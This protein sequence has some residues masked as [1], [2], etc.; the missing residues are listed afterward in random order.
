MKRIGEQLKEAGIL[1]W[2]DEWELQP[3]QPWQDELE[4]QIKQVK[5]VAVFLGPS[6]RGPWHNAEMRAAIDQFNTRECPVIPVILPD[7]EGDPEWPLLLQ[8]MHAIDFREPDPEPLK[9]LIWG[10]TGRRER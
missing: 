9:Q 3:G 1:P 6:G 7:R 8:S 4:R 5:S 10:I 2:L